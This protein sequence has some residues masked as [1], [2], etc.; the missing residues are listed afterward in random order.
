MGRPL[1]SPVPMP[2]GTHTDCIDEPDRYG[3][4]DLIIG[5]ATL[6]W[7]AARRWRRDM[8]GMSLRGLLW[9]T[10]VGVGFHTA[11]YGH[12]L[13]RSGVLMGVVYELGYDTNP[14]GACKTLTPSSLSLS[15][16]R[17][18]QAPNSSFSVCVEYFR[19]ISF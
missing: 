14:I 15:L 6:D 11:G 9:M 10:P 19:V 1:D 12:L 2:E 18:A 13:L 17:S 7:T 3:C 4:F 5:V 16:G 8:A